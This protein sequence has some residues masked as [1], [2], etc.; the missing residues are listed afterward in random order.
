MKS[1]RTHRAASPE[2]SSDFSKFF[3][4]LLTQGD[5]SRFGRNYLQVGMYTEMMFPDKD[6]R[7]IAINNNVDS[8]KQDD[9]DFT[10]FL[11]IINVLFCF[12]TVFPTA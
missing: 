2:T 12:S 5:M 1:R 4:S 10:P 6:V 11:N 8:D 3:G 7:F 9:N